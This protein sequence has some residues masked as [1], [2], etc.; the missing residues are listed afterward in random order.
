MKGHRIYL[1]GGFRSG[2]QDRV[3]QACPELEFF[4]PR[5]HQLESPEQYT[6]WD[7]HH[8][9]QCDILF[10]YMEPNNPSGLGLALE[11]GYARALAKLVV[12]VDEKS[13]QDKEFALY[14]AITRTA[15]D[16][17][18]DALEAGIEFIASFER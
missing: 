17:V 15:A 5:M 11:V 13:P 1:S 8:L 4:D 6:F 12:I 3:I 2:W 10:G 14:F 18:L 7:L 9:Q 16:V